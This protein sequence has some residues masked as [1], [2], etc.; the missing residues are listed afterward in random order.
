[1]TRARTSQ[2]PR[3]AARGHRSTLHEYG[4]ALRIKRSSLPLAVR[5]PAERALPE[6]TARA[7]AKSVRRAVL[8]G[9]GILLAAWATAPA[10]TQHGGTG[11]AG[12]GAGGSAANGGGGH[13][14]FSIIGAKL[15]DAGTLRLTFD[16]A[17]S[18]TEHFDVR[19]FRLSAAVARDPGT[20]YR[21]CYECSYAYLAEGQCGPPV[22]SCMS[23]GA[24]YMCC[25]FGKPYETT[26][27]YDPGGGQLSHPRVGAT[28]HELL[29]DVAIALGVCDPL[30]LHFTP[31]AVFEDAQGDEL[32]PFG[33]PKYVAGDYVLF[34][35][36]DGKF[37]GGAFRVEGSTCSAT[38]HNGVLDNGETSIDC[39]GDNLCPRC[40]NGLAC[41][42]NGDCA[43]GLCIPPAS[44]FGVG[45]CG[46]AGCDDGVRDGDEAE[47]D[48]GGGC[49]NCVGAS[50]AQPSDC[51]TG[52]C[53]ANTCVTNTAIQ[54]AAQVHGC[55][56]TVGGAV[57]CWGDNLHGDVGDGTTIARSVPVPVPGWSSGVAAITAGES[58]TCALTGGGS[59]QCLGSNVYGQL[60]IG[61]A[62]DQHAPVTVQGLGAGV[63]LVSAAFSGEHACALV[64]GAVAC[65]GRN[66]HGQL[67][68]GTLVSQ[69]TPVAVVG[70]APGVSVIASGALHTCAITSAG[71]VACWGNNTFGELG[72]GP[73]GSQGALGNVAGLA[74]PATA[75]TAGI[76]F[77]C[78]LLQGG[79]VQCWGDAAS[80][81]LGSS[82]PTGPTPVTVPGVT[83]LAISAGTASAC[84][85]TASQDITCWG[86]NSSG[87]LG[88]GDILPVAGPTQVQGLAAGSA[89]TI[90]VGHHTACA[91][92][93]PGRVLCWG[94]G[95]TEL[96]LGLAVATQYT[97]GEI[98][99]F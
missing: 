1:M 71:D 58:F 70:L 97:P 83:A 2:L 9:V 65:W 34:D 21:S 19:G 57:F 91:V 46:V 17:L 81:Q 6:G 50:C 61:G 36:E 48:C 52:V 7:T 75:I 95:A 29:A 11:A 38:C 53:E 56:L 41:K 69:R 93:I 64:G 12:G 28:S 4:S 74:G 72:H 39:G 98:D 13:G 33:S 60:G 47:I 18:P 31:R 88:T 92:T 42:V 3:P 62:G 45:I 82:V 16:E 84:A 20:Y 30:Y 67:G 15:V 68:D 8:S 78:A 54:V 59:V 89:T 94:S 76:G 51:V 80:G 63:T 23:S 32:L 77:T 79:A 26:R 5:S 96:G 27:Y 90:S 40:P 99:K 22:S 25:V 24:D 55:A 44:G 73:L 87:Q 37:A 35:T 14:S 49:A 85:L 10:C 86:D 66:D 43:G